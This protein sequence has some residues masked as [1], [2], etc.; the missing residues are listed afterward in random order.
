[1]NHHAE[2]EKLLKEKNRED[3]ELTDEEFLFNL[4]E[5][6]MFVPVM[7]GTDQ[8]DVDRLH[9]MAVALKAEKGPKYDGWGGE[10]ATKE[11]VERW[12]AEGK[13]KGAR[14]LVVVCDTFDYGDYPVYVMPGEDVDAVIKKYRE[15]E[16]S[17]VM[18]TIDL[19]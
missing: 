11:D 18:E 17:R 12:K 3:R 6:L 8:Y 16:M 2:L 13:R 7:F 10:T 19:T 1:M 14:W 9:A 5:R 4:S 15:A